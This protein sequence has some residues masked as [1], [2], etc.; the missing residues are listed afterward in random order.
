MLPAIAARH[1]PA[2]ADSR[3]SA[4][5]PPAENPSSPDDIP[6]GMR[7][8]ELQKSEKIEGSERCAGKRRGTAK[9]G[10]GFLERRQEHEERMAQRVAAR[11]RAAEEAE[12]AAKAKAVEEARRAKEKVRRRAEKMARKAEQAQVAR[13]VVSDA[14]ATA[15]SKQLRPIFGG[16]NGNAAADR[17]TL[18]RKAEAE[19]AR[20]ELTAARLKA[21]AKARADA[22]VAAQSKR[23]AALGLPEAASD[24]QCEALEQ[25]RQEEAAKEKLQMRQQQMKMQE[26]TLEESRL[27]AEAEARA[28]YAAQ[29]L[30]AKNQA[31][32][33]QVARSQAVKQEEERL[34]AEQLA[35]IEAETRATHA[36]RALHNGAARTTSAGLDSES[37]TYESNANSPGPQRETLLPHQSSA[38]DSRLPTEGHTF[39]DKEDPRNKPLWAASATELLNELMLRQQ[40]PGP[41]NAPSA[42]PPQLPHILPLSVCKQSDQDGFSAANAGQKTGTKVNCTPDKSRST[43]DAVAEAA[44]AEAAAAEAAEMRVAEKTARAAE[45]RR[46]MAEAKA[47][48]A[49]KAAARR[50]E[51]AARA[52]SHKMVD[53]AEATVAP[54]D[55]TA[56]ICLAEGIDREYMAGTHAADMRKMMLEARK[57]DESAKAIA[58]AEAAA[59]EAHFRDCTKLDS[60]GTKYRI[61]PDGTRVKVVRKPCP[62]GED[63]RAAVHDMA[64]A[65]GWSEHRACMQQPSLKS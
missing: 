58:A 9:T 34:L 52:K 35:R 63:L 2:D 59:A 54:E 15:A 3:K 55:S 65:A 47:E 17:A 11:K 42:L 29:M 50:R 51:A 45:R 23:R 19:R 46:K 4:N 36:L 22:E 31:E 32:A 12:N 6:V 37:D 7:L 40:Q 64:K 5:S 43:P 62:Q 44:A 33:E 21:Q 20:Q 16:N 41:S 18:I 38:T 14:A 28:L 1:L 10:P 61:K 49:E 26:A 25:K 24:A 30:E 53:E 39:L 57:R 48:K 8:A 60:D 13:Q 27:R 56:S